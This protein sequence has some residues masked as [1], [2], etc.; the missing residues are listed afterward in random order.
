VHGAIEDF[1]SALASLA[2]R[3]LLLPEW[4]GT[5][6]IVV[7]GGLPA[8]ATGE[9]IIRRARAL[10][11][12]GGVRAELRAIHSHPHDAALIG[13][14]HL[15]PG[16]LL[17]EH[18]AILAVDIG[19]TNVRVGVVRLRFA[20][21]DD[22]PKTRVWKRVLWRHADEKI[23]RDHVVRSIVKIMRKLIKK[24]ERKG[25]RL[26]PLI[27][28]AVPGSIA[29]D[30]SIGSGSEVLPGN[31]RSEGFNLPARLREEIQTIGDHETLVRLHNDAVV[32]GLSEIPYTRDYRH[33]AVLTV[34]T[35]LGNARFTTVV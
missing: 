5:E 19:G 32:Q 20:S 15:V 9:L 4:E 3:F 12:A 23:G 35:G 26:A 14:A 1:S 25:F 16:W 6:C 2:E 28:V 17:A 11:H 29:A 13:A 7:G 22:V 27:G 33:W 34:G 30:G 24:A 21:R 8:S 31:W 10:L 18:D